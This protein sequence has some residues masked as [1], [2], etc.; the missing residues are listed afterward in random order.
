M[1]FLSPHLILLN[2]ISADPCTVLL[3]KMLRRATRL[4]DQKPAAVCCRQ[5]RK[6]HCYSER[7]PVDNKVFGAT[8]CD[9]LLEKVNPNE[10]PAVNYNIIRRFVPFL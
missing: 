9:L 4:L 6:I 5:R 10:S 1:N 2:D 8:L 3:S 7:R